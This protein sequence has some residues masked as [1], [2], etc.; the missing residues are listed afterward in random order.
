MTGRPRVEEGGLRGLVVVDKPVGPT[1]HDVIACA[2]RVLGAKAGHLGTLDPLA[3]GVLPVL[4]GQATRL[5]ASIGAQDKE[6]LAEIR[7]GRTTDTYDREG[8]VV[9]VRPAP[10][11][12]R[13]EIDALLDRFRGEIRQQ[14]PMYSAVRI[15]GRRLYELARRRQEI[16]RPSRTV[17]I[18]R[19]ELAGWSVDL[20]RLEIHCS[21]GT[22]VR[23]LAHEIGQA[24][25]CGAFLENLRRTRVGRFDL[26][27]AV[28]LGASASEWRSRMVPVEE[29]L[30]D[31]VRLDLTPGQAQRVRHGNPVD[32]PSELRGACSLLHRGRLLAV[33]WSDGVQVHPKVVLESVS[34]QLD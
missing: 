6:Y 8:R 20:W 2:R 19:L 28:G 18:H 31:L 9:E 21:S 1:S 13:S 26:G 11:L 5:A 34:D 15:G 3:S 24:A 23:S 32:S 27:M 30:P 33:G 4:V 14:P 25:G 22:Y 29:L 16:D 7:L 17:S 12:T 10:V